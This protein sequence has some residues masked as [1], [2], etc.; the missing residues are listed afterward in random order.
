MKKVCLISLSIFILLLNSC[1]KRPEVTLVL[2]RRITLV[3]T[4]YPSTAV[5]LPATWTPGPPASNTPEPSDT[6]WLIATSEMSGTA[7]ATPDL[8]IGEGKSGRYPDIQTSLVFV[9]Q[10]GERMAL[11]SLE[12]GNAVPRRLLLGKRDVFSPLWSPDG[13]QLAYLKIAEYEEYLAEILGRSWP[14]RLAPVDLFL[15]VAGLEMPLGD[16]GTMFISDLSWSPDSTM[17]AYSGEEIDPSGEPISGKNIY[18][19]S[20]ISLRQSQVIKTSQGNVGC[21]SPTWDPSSSLI[22]ARCRGL[23]AIGLAAAHPDGSDPFWFEAQAG[24]VR[25]RPDGKEILIVNGWYP[26]ATIDPDYVLQYDRNLNLDTAD[27]SSELSALGVQEKYVLGFAWAPG[28]ADRFLIQSED[29]IQVVDRDAGMLLTLEGDFR[30]LEGQFSWGPAGNQIALAYF[31]GEDAEIGVLNFV[32]GTFYP[33]TVNEVDDL[34][35]A[36][37]PYQAGDE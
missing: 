27:L 21:S 6:P 7:P 13:T 20:I 18:Q 17:I 19:T 34:M 24:A 12:Q 9:R 32:Q 2:D 35:P 36:W 3:N 31:D 23:M 10:D 22:L 25:W 30:D 15:Y 16:S 26:L 28:Q 29:L 1:Q 8:I 14:S 4:A 33:L 37:Q 11:Y 5:K